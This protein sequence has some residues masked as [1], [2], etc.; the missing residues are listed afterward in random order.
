MHTDQ[1]A[2]GGG[3]STYADGMLNEFEDKYGKTHRGFIDT[4]SEIY[5]TY[6][7]QYPNNSDKLRLISPKKYRTQMVEEMIELMDIG[8]I[9]FPYE[10][11][12]QDCVKLIKEIDASGNE[13]WENHE[14]SDDEKLALVQIDLMK[15][16][17]T[18]IHK[19]QNA[20]KTSVNYALSKEKE[21]RM[22]DDRFYVLIMLAHRL[23]ELRRG[24]IVNKEKPVEEEI[25]F[26]GRA[27]KSYK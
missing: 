24:N 25:C 1:G 22:H 16:E 2:G 3:V 10:Y 27:A 13:I 26:F 9:H 5:E 18:S 7:K 4:S 19:T 6:I 20:E 12:G 15:T 8:V 11:S 21:T 23:Y 14:L 17:V